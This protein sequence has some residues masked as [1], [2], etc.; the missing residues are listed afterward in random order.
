MGIPKDRSP[1]WV[2]TTNS[3]ERVVDMDK[4]LVSEQGHNLLAACDTLMKAIN[5]SLKRQANADKR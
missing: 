5:P 2:T 4:A 1:D 3:G